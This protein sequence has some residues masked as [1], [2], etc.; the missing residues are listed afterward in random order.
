MEPEKKENLEKFNFKNLMTIAGVVIFTA[1]CIIL[2]YF[3]V[4][5]YSGFSEGWN[6]FVKVWTGIIIGF[7]LAFLMNP[8]MD[9]FEKKTLPFFLRHTRNEAK[10]RKSV[11]VLWSIVALAVIVGIITIFFLYVIPELYSTMKFLVDHLTEQI[12]GVLDWANH[13]TRGH[14]EKQLNDA[15]HSDINAAIEDGLDWVQN[16]LNL[17]T[18]QVVKQVVTG[19]ISVGRLLVDIVIGLIVSVYV[20]C[21]KE[22]FKAQAKKIIYSIFAPK[23]ANVVLEI[24]RKTSDIFYGFIIGKIIDSLIIGI[25][26]AIFMKIAG[27]PYILLCSVIIGVTNIIPVFGPY[28][29][30][31]PTVIIIFLT[32]PPQGITFLI[33]V[34]ILQQIDGNI[35]GPAILG[36]STGLSPFWVVVAIVVGGGLFGVPGMIIGVP[37][38]ALIYYLVGRLTSYRVRKKGLPEETDDYYN[39][40]RV[41][42]ANNTIINHDPD[43]ERSKKYVNIKMLRRKKRVPKK[44]A[45]KSE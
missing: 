10:T 25:I 1:C 18:D 19:A 33:F 32:N 43:Y 23:N 30:A 37:T 9:F 7:V 38:M 4:Q 21:S 14:F 11:R 44:Q 16:Y 17:T 40:E 5:R 24:A 8:I 6:K 27:L 2:F 28:F 36:D 26:C 13:V 15:K 42:E 20:L 35:I 12:Q 31:V 3:I 22:S 45:D 34:I 29:G 39:M 41:D